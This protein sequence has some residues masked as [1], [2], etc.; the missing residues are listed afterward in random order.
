[1]LIL[2]V[3]EQIGWHRLTQGQ[4]HFTLSVAALQASALMPID[5]V[6]ADPF[7][8]FS[9]GK[10]SFVTRHVKQ[11][12]NP[13]WEDE[14]Y[15]FRVKSLNQVL[16][17]EVFDHNSYSS[18]VFLGEYWINMKDLVLDEEYDEWHNLCLKPN[19][20]DVVAQRHR[21]GEGLGE[22]RLKM[23]LR[24]TNIPACELK[25]GVKLL[26]APTFKRP[27][28]NERIIHHRTLRGIGSLELSV[29]SASKMQGHENCRP[30]VEVSVGD[31]FEVIKIVRGDDHPCWDTPFALPVAPGAKTLSC[32]ILSMGPKKRKYMLGETTIFLDPLK[33][34]GEVDAWYRLDGRTRLGQL[35]LRVVSAENLLAADSNGK[36]DPFV[37]V[38]F[39]KLKKKTKTKY[40][41]L[42]PVWGEE[43]AFDIFSIKD[44]IEIEIFDW[45]AIGNN[46]LLGRKT[47]NLTDYFVN[48]KDGKGP[49]EG[50]FKISER[51]KLEG[52]NGTMFVDTEQS[53]RVQGSIKVE[54]S[55]HGDPSLLEKVGF[56]R[57]VTNYICPAKSVK[58]A[59][60]MEMAL[61]EGGADHE[62]YDPWD[63]THFDAVENELEKALG[64]APK[65]CLS[66]AKLSSCLGNLELSDNSLQAQISVF[67]SR[68][69]Q[70]A[71]A[72]QLASVRSRLATQQ[73]P[74]PYFPNNTDNPMN[75]RIVLGR[76]MSKP[77]PPITPPK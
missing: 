58:E 7:L 49:G 30:W 63:E 26:R 21:D 32:K 28:R 41:T 55:Y 59:A 23:C 3:F 34:A 6:T 66:K 22:I 11:N 77:K 18:H 37:Q 60:E 76:G 24:K 17:C 68:G 33:G 16:R 10:Q 70:V 50:R 52:L 20:R 38:T 39:G 9:V 46:D 15:T 74:T 31:Q 5:G 42:D 61:V 47:I 53:E 4:E 43:F 56:L 64:P 75:E 72:K 14:R 12:V 51:L 2:C 1:M 19:Q 13:V 69:G 57:L 29:V 62:G 73:V 45:D 8:K 40:K 71:T 48:R 27:H 35:I 54:I 25:M 65:A 36:S 67:K 44:K